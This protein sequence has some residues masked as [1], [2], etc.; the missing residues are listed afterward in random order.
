[1]NAPFP[2]NPQ[3]GQRF[4]NWMW[5]GS[6]WVCTA[7]AGVRVVTQVFQASAP[8]MPSPGLISAVVESVG[9]G[10]AGGGVQTVAAT[11]A[12]SGGGGGAGG[13]SRSTLAAALLAGGVNV[14]IGAAGQRSGVGLVGGNGGVTSFGALCVA[15]GGMGGMAN[16]LSP[17]VGYGNGGL[18]GSI[19]GAIGADFVSAGNPGLPG[20][21]IVSNLGAEIPI[22]GG[23][24]AAGPWGGAGFTVFVG[25]G[26]FEPGGDGTGPGAGGAGGAVNMVTGAET[27]GSGFPGICIVTE[28]CWVDASDDG[29]DGTVNVSARVA[30][31]DGWR[32]RPMQGPEGFDD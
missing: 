26:Q 6:R 29:C 19:V 24:G 30:V 7:S 31:T 11:T 5:N 10:A 23:S 32:P 22:P 20:T 13:Y 8:Y 27:G 28:T 2:V 15:N 21:I 16:G 18:G 25:E 1:M 12:L 9:G 14:T 4:G 17:A 3:V